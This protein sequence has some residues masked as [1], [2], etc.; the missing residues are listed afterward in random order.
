[1]VR[2]VCESALAQCRLSCITVSRMYT[3]ALCLGALMAGCSSTSTRS[4]ADGGP[5]AGEDSGALSEDAP[6]DGTWTTVYRKYFGAG[7][8]GHCGNTNCH[9]TSRAGFRCGPTKDTCYEGLVGAGLLDATK[10]ASSVLIDPQAS[11]LAWFGGAMPADN[12]VPNERA[13]STLRTWVLGGAHN[14]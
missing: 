13:A 11:P 10:P 4:H 8:P 6:D 5:N 7:T 3:I 14:D 12:A 2:F 1:M 9:N